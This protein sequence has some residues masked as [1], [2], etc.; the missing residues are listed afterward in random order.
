MGYHY[1]PDAG[2]TP[3]P[4]PT[5][6][7]HLLRVPSEY[8]S[9]QA[10][11][12]AAS[13]GDTVL[14]ANGTYRGSGFRNIQYN[15][16]EIAVMSENG[17]TFCTVDCSPSGRG[18][19][20]KNNE[21]FNAILQGFTIT[22]AETSVEGGGI[23][24]Y[25]A[26][27]V[28]ADCIITDCTADS[29]AGVYCY[30]CQ[31]TFKNCLITGNSAVEYGGGFAAEDAAVELTNCTI[32]DNTADY[33]GGLSFLNCPLSSAEN[34]IVWNNSAGTS[35]DQIY[36]SGNPP[37]IDYSDVQQAAQTY[38]GTGNINQN[39]QFTTG[40]GGRYYLNDSPASPCFNIGHGSSGG[41]CFP[42]LSES[43]CMDDLTTQED[44]ALDTGIVDMGFHYAVITES[45]PTDT[46]TPAPTDT[47]TPE[48]ATPTPSTPV[49]SCDEFERPDS[50]TVVNWTER[51]GDWRI[52][53]TRL[54]SEATSIIQ[55]ITY[56]GV[57]Q[58]DGCVKGR[59]VHG[60]GTDFQS[61]GVLARYSSTANN[62]RA[63]LVDNDD[64]G[65]WD[66]YQI[67]QG[68]T[69]LAS[70]HDYN[71]GADAYIQLRYIA[72][73]V[74]FRVD[75]DRNGSWDYTFNHEVSWTGS[76]KAGVSA[77]QQCFMDDWCAG[78]VCGPWVPPT[79]TPTPTPATPSGPCDYF[80]RP[81]STDVFQ[82]TERR[83]NWEIVGNR[84]RPES[85][86]L[87][88]HITHDGS[89]QADGC[90]Q[91]RAIFG[92]GTHFRF[93]GLLAR[94]IAPASNIRA[95]LKAGEGSTYWDSYLITQGTT[96]IYT[97]TG[98]DF[99]TD[100]YIQFSY[101]GSD[102]QFQV[103]TDRDGNWDYTFDHNVTHLDS[104]GTGVSGYNECYMDDWCT[105]SD[106]GPWIPPT[107]TPTLAP[108]TDTPVPPTDTPVIPTNTPPGPPCPENS[109]FSQPLDISFPMGSGYASDPD[110]DPMYENIAFENYSVDRLI[111]TVCW[112]G[113]GVPSLERDINFTFYVDDNGQPGAVYD[114]RSGRA[115]A[116]ETEYTV[117]GF[118]VYYFYYNFSSCVDLSQGWISIEGLGMGDDNVFY[119]ATG[120]DGDSMAYYQEM[121]FFNEIGY[122]LALCILTTDPTPIPT[123]TPVPPPCPDGSVHSQPLNV[124][125]LFMCGPASDPDSNSESDTIAYDNYSTTDV[126]C[127]V[128]WWGCCV[129]NLE[130]QFDITFYQDNNGEPGA[131]YALRIGFAE[132]YLTEF[133][134]DGDPIYHFTM[135]F[136][137]CV[138]LMQGW[139]SVEG[140][141]QGYSNVFYWAE[142]LYGDEI[143]YQ[144]DWNDLME[145]PF[146]LS[147]CLRS[148]VPTPT[149]AP[150][151]TPT[152]VGAPL[153]GEVI[154]ERPGQDVP[155]PVFSSPLTV[156]LCSE[157]AAHATYPASTDEF[158]SFMIYVDKGTWDILVKGE[159]TLAARRNDILIDD[160]GSPIVTFG[161][162][163]EGDANGDNN[164]ISTDF[165]IL[166]FTY[167]KVEGE[168]GY[169][170]RADFNEDQMVTSTDFFLLR[171]NYNKAGETCL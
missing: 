80:D 156:T 54:T 106:C 153:F 165:F 159:H 115:G 136:A 23:L 161:T 90:I 82:W 22:G 146:D 36:T 43:I 62:I 127:A 73:N 100:A 3:T 17:P 145:Y 102:V 144:Y 34:L 119:W 7:P 104:G 69:L 8:S 152:P 93:T 170:D 128:E 44:N 122:D 95:V 129:P 139:M 66:S 143:S 5:P 131:E 78:E 126:I 120:V 164:V 118:P 6:V 109:N 130:T 13:N 35:D 92:T 56:N 155:D 87:I 71:F 86:P 88:Q 48:P 31:A 64:S 89:D 134:A 157:G 151:F 25:R 77:F 18:F 15:G 150:T 97:G 140:Q 61:I 28:I 12:D 160:V 60:I 72:E 147:F 132:A 158:G 68:T 114:T 4:T 53:G 14:V 51:R 162:L 111:Q 11:I 49:G 167:N 75:T 63:M 149:P 166:R 171:N 59:A 57:D 38:P 52:D 83:G 141:A 116:I 101:Y 1:Y 26:S 16:K 33:G 103:D 168:P 121:E 74:R 163:P 84:L 108:P 39:P 105:G 85:T 124:I 169:D 76:G 45:V 117:Y 65:Y 9:I 113:F 81:N 37:D 41:I 42:G 91:G 135:E 79:A 21:N 70:G 58:A 107:H 99:G 98:F 94:Y 50:T 112:W 10:G 148:R 142:G 67:I 32:A 47:F 123:D 110:F 133:N 154:F 19:L 29:A 46:P 27:P 137:E 2:S 96:G 138:D 55:H 20:F 40:P 30:D 24:C 125:N